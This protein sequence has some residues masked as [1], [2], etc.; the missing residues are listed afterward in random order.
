[1]TTVQSWTYSNDAGSASLEILSV[2]D[3]QEVPGYHLEQK[4][5]AADRDLPAQLGYSCAISDR[6]AVFGAPF[7][8]RD[9]YRWRFSL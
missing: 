8:D 3:S 2:G 1:M 4:V 6:V 9:R 7:E 5:I